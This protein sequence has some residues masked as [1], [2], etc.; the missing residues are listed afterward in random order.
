MQAQQQQ[1][2]NNAVP[3]GSR[4]PGAVSIKSPAQFQKSEEL[5][6]T[7][8]LFPARNEN[9]VSF[10]QPP[11]QRKT[12]SGNSV[13]VFQFVRAA[14]AGAWNAALALR[15]LQAT[16]AQQQINTL[17]TNGLQLATT[18]AARGELANKQTL[19]RNT[20]ESIRDGRM[21]LNVLTQSLSCHLTPHNYT[22]WAIGSLFYNRVPE[23]ARNGNLFFDSQVIYPN[24]GVNQAAAAGL[25]ENHHNNF[26]RRGS[27]P[28]HTDGKQIRLF[29]PDGATWLN[30]NDILK[31]IIIHE[32][33]HAIDRHD[34]ALPGNFA[35]ERMAD[36]GPNQTYGD[37]ANR[38]KTEFR[39]YWLGEKPGGNFGSSTKRAKNNRRPETIDRDDAMGV[40]FISS[41]T[42]FQNE[43][44]ENIFWHLVDTSYKWVETNYAES[45]KFRTMVDAYS[46]P[47]GGNL[48][49]STRID[50]Y[51]QQLNFNKGS[52]V[53]MAAAPKAGQRAAFL[54]QLKG[55]RGTFLPLAIALDDNDRAFLSSPELSQ[56]FWRFFDAVF[57]DLGDEH[58]NTYHQKTKTALKRNMNI[59]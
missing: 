47:T 10:F 7:E 39:A 38:Y 24:N 6:K 46:E 40:S 42:S 48:L 44:Q 17:V 30:N 4:S 57:P 25:D 21:T 26:I 15:T 33:Q 3:A 8:S 14:N 45:E 19:F 29:M 58:L 11:L 23:S 2:K 32:G 41:A 49:N 31:T 12:G 51:A 53:R 55:L 50:H 54:N 43:R 37:V 5:P 18:R 35:D 52:I 36:V 59:D 28:A 56:P 34:A 1:A 9:E 27:E 22:E 13:P 16:N 20:C